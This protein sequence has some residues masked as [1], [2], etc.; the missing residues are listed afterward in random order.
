MIRE[1]PS[2]GRCSPRGRLSGEG[3]EDPLPSSAGGELGIFWDGDAGSHFPAAAFAG[4]SRIPNPR[5]ATPWDGCK[6]PKMAPGPQNAAT[7]PRWPQA[8]QNSPK[9]QNVAKPLDG[10]TPPRTPQFLQFIPNYPDGCNPPRMFQPPKRLQPPWMTES[11]QNSQ[12][13]W[14]V[15]SPRKV[16]KPLDGC[17]P[18]RR[19]QPSVDAC[20]ASR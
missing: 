9:S 7:S 20:K 2:K 5:C 18:P 19:L 3:G 11:P 17:R 6:P 4:L 13:L 15:A 1:W 16:K 8:P 10:S 14:M 12:P